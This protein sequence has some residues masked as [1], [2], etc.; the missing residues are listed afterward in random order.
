M[1]REGDSEICYLAED[2]KT[3]VCKVEAIVSVDDRGQMI[4]PKELRDK[5]GIS[6]GAKLAVIGWEKEGQLCCISLVKVEDFSGMING[7][8]APM[9]KEV[10][11]EQDV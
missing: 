8:L 1:R 7:L 6:G 3:C 10:V 11:G 2:K 5:A 9:M 4:L